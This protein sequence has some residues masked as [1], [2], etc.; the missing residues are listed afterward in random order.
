MKHMR[1]FANI[2]NSG[3]SQD[4]V[5]EA[6]VAACSGYDPGLLH[7]SNQGYSAWIQII[8]ACVCIYYI[9]NKKKC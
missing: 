1:A 5:E 7:P 6:F 4:S 3:V 2:C 8:Y 9:Y